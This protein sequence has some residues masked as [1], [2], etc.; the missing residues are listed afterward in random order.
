[1][2]KPHNKYERKE[3]YSLYYENTKKLFKQK[4]KEW[5]LRGAH[6]HHKTKKISKA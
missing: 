3:Y 6:K 5:V 1:M 2:S 4:P